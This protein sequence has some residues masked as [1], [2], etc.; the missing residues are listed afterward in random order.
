MMDFIASKEVNSK[1][2]LEIIN[3]SPVIALLPLAINN[4]DRI[5]LKI[6]KNNIMLVCNQFYYLYSLV[7]LARLNLVYSSGIITEKIAKSIYTSKD[8]NLENLKESVS[9][10]FLLSSI[11]FYNSSF[12]YL[13]VFIKYSYSSYNELII[14]YPQEKIQKTMQQL[15]L[16][17]DWYLALAS[18]INR[19]DINVYVKWFKESTA[20]KQIK[21]LF[22]NLRKHNVKLRK[23]YQ[24]NSVKHCALP[25]FQRSDLSN[26]IGM[27]LI[28]SLEH[29][30]SKK[31]L[32]PQKFLLGRLDSRFRIDEVQNFLI[33]YHNGTAKVI[34]EIARDIG[35]H[36]SDTDK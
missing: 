5:S 34:N 29:F 20:P 31:E 19:M 11:I 17:D 14:E 26:T 12:D 36:D 30:Y 27:L 1:G 18:S 7:E 33:E 32:H 22:A 3:T 35:L 9:I 28:E 6:D 16:K 2:Q 15:H 10:D 13:K 8:N 21:E 4:P 24:A 23:D 25:Y